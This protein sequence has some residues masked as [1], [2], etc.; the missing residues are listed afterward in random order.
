VLFITLYFASEPKM[1]H[2]KAQ[3][4]MLKMQKKFTPCSRMIVQIA[5]VTNVINSF[6]RTLLL[7]TGDCMKNFIDFV[8]VT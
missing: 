8:F 2:W 1:Y 5:V 4:L 6:R 3:N 7:N